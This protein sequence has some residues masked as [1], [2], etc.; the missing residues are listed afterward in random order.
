[1]G[2]KSLGLVRGT[3]VSKAAGGFHSAN[4]NPGLTPLSRSCLPA[5]L[6]LGSTSALGQ[7]ARRAHLFAEIL[8][9]KAR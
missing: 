4:G 5:H 7:R 6:P 3:G 8:E 9:R 2:I 1:M